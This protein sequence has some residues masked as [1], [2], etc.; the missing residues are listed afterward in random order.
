M[1]FYLLSLSCAAAVLLFSGC[2]KE[3]HPTAQKATTVQ[4]PKVAMILPEY[5]TF[6]AEISATASIQPSPDGIVSVSAPVAGSVDKIY[7]N[8]GDKISS[9][10]PLLT[11]RSTDVSDTQSDELSAKAA[12]TQAKHVH[13]MNKEL[14][15]LGAIT[16]NDL[17]LSQSNQQQAEAV[18]K[19][20]SQKL[21]YFGASSSQALTLHAPISGVVYEIETHLGEKVSNDTAQALVKIANIHKKIVVATVYEKDLPSFYVGKE[22]DI[23]LDNGEIE[24]IKGTVTYVSD[25]LDPENK[26]TKV[27]IQPAL[28]SSALKIN[29]FAN[30]SLQ[31]EKKDVFRIP[32]RSILF[33]EGKFVVY[34]KKGDQFSPLNVTLVRDDPQ[35]NYSLVKGLPKNTSIALEAIALEKE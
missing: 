11:I 23:K 30:I 16:A 20:F 27:Y 3:D 28:D 4:E 32:K 33:K 10:S 5:G 8:V 18:L 31:A 24:P 22:V 15:K 25:V 7:V 21:N 35:D 6:N 1:R 14:F 17:A 29:M 12:Y 34:V 2:H 9:G 19:G 26:T 13:E